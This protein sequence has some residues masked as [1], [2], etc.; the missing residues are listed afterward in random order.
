M[1]FKSKARKHREARG[2]KKER[3]GRRKELGDGERA[4]TISSCKNWADKSHGGR[5][6]SRENALDVWEKG[7]VNSDNRRIHIC[8][9]HYREYKKATKEEHENRWY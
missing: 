8:K 3:K 9:P 5:S 1:G 7:D 6:I 4:C 2:E